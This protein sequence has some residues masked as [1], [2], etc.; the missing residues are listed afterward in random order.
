MLIGGILSSRLYAEWK[1]AR[2]SKTTF[3]PCEKDIVVDNL[4]VFVLTFSSSSCNAS[5]Y[6]EREGKEK[7]EN[8]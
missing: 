2:L 4:G 7:K 8:I 5:L 1:D 6:K 3:L